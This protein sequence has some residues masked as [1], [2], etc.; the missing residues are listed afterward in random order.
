MKHLA[1]VETYEEQFIRDLALS[2]K[3]RQA[4]HARGQMTRIYASAKAS[5][6]TGNWGATVTSADSEISESLRTLRARSRQ[7]VRDAPYAKRAKTIVVNNVVGAGIGIQAQV[8][9]SRGG[10][11][12][13]VNNDIESAWD[14]WCE[15]GSCHTGGAL[16]FSDLERVALGEVFE[17]G[18]IFLRLHFRPFGDSAVPLA[19]EVMESERVVDEFQPGALTETGRVRLGIELD[20][21]HR[22]V[23]YFVRRIHPG[24]IS[25][26]ARDID[27]I[28][29]IDAGYILHLRIVDRWP[30]TRGIPWM[31]AAA[32]RLN[33]MDGYSEAEIIAARGAASYMGLIEM[34]DPE[35]YMSGET[36]AESGDREVELEPGIVQKL[37]P[38]EKF[39]FVNPS[40]PNAAMDPFMRMMLREV[41]AGVGVS[42]ESLSR[43]YSQS[44]YS[45]SRL[46]LLDDRDLW[47]VCQLWFIRNFRQILHRIWMRQAVLSRVIPSIGID[48]YALNM[49]KFNAVRYKPRGW[50]WIDPTKEVEAYKQA[51]R[52]G[53]TTVGE[54]IALT[55][56]GRDLED[57]LDERR[58]EL[59]MMAGRDLLF[60]TDPTADIEKTQAEGKSAD[61]QAAQ[62]ADKTVGGNGNG[63]GQN[64]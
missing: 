15:A 3:D 18:E 48:E 2:L 10:L 31:H 58:Q 38:G 34:T 49:N 4:L 13:R 19:I 27:G 5:R 64:N 23:A 22:A 50:S 35:F 61:S 51:V 42:Y 56:G 53:F 16:H 20:P 57:V 62:P 63:T 54:V 37:A 30:Q 55:G 32:R 11:S 33:D 59:D 29:R 24:E 8:R 46:A 39:N 52:C 9:N 1:R 25:L 14:Q 17:A 28:D 44:N 21:F 60:E 45:S 12:D 36:L 47:K 40:R 43:D 6:L 41:A 7:L 26:S